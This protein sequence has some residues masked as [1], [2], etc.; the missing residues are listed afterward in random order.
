MS[1]SSFKIASILDSSSLVKTHSFVPV[2]GVVGNTTEFDF[3]RELE[4]GLFL[5]LS[6][7][8]CFNEKKVS[9]KNYQIKKVSFQKS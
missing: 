2:G 5:L 8:A 9:D 4:G 6:S 3:E 7:F 1:L